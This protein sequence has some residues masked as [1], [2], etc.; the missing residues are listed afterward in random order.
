MQFYRTL[1]YEYFFFCHS[2]S[3]FCIYP[4]VFPTFTSIFLSSLRRVSIVSAPNTLCPLA[5]M[6]IWFSAH[7]CCYFL[8]RYMISIEFCRFLAQGSFN[9]LEIDTD[10][11]RF[12][13]NYSIFGYIMVT[14]KI[15]H[16]SIA[17]AKKFLPHY[18]P[19][20]RVTTKAATQSTE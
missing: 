9:S 15:L 19:S 7:S 13:F 20:I 5:T 11:V 12:T 3:L 18:F 17:F 1:Y 6:H 10:F 8:C 4:C 2:F 14:H 16:I